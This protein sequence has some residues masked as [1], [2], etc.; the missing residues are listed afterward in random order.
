MN[1]ETLQKIGR[2]HSVDEIIESFN[3]AREIGFDNINMDII[4]GLE[5]ETLEH[6]RHTLEEIK[7]L[8]PESLT[9]HTLAIKRASKLKEQMDN[10]ELT[11]YEEMIKMI[12]LSMEYAK[13]MGLNPYYLYRQKQMLG[14][15]ENIGYSKEGYECIY[16]SLIHISE[17]TR[18]SP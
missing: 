14:N 12:D 7:K 13:D 10:Y 15:L 1:D 3:L 11:Q 8:S 16:L 5:G 18:P 9:V 6:V 4:L 17:P 2:G